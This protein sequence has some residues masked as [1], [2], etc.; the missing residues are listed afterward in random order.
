M[1]PG[2]FSSKI[3]RIHDK[4][5][6]ARGPIQK[7]LHDKLSAHF[8]AAIRAFITAAVESVKIDTA[9]SVASFLPLAQDVRL[10]GLI[11]GKISLRERQSAYPHTSV[12]PEFLSNLGVKKSASFGAEL[13]EDCYRIKYGTPY[14]PVF[15]FD[16]NIPVYQY[17]LHETGKV[18]TPWK[19]LEAGYTAMD[20]YWRNNFNGKVGQQ[21][22]TMLH[23]WI[24]TGNVVIEES[25]NE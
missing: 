1:P 16:F 19:S 22:L 13:G 23:Q 17:F 20:A 18:G 14:K 11:E 24:L 15:I 2:L 6:G 8:R 9:M 7:K 3:K 5:R 4:W 25:A 21:V 10:K 12:P